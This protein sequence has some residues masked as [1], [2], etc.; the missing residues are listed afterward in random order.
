MTSDNI[1][2]TIT[3]WK[4]AIAF[5]VPWKPE[6]DHG[7][8]SKPIGLADGKSDTLISINPRFLQLSLS[9]PPPSPSMIF[10][11]P[12]ILLPDEFPMN[13]NLLIMHTN[14]SLLQ[15]V[16]AILETAVSF[17]LCTKMRISS[18]HHSVI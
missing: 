17:I 11:M 4:K 8:I 1:A 10:V 18:G 2:V 6:T 16:L 7:A 3:G 13:L 9:L 12:R 15:S 14:F 5:S